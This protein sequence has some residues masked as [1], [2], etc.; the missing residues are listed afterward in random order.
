MVDYLKIGFITAPFGN[1]GEVKVQV[2]TD[3]PER[4]ND[5]AW[6]FVDTGDSI[7]KYY[8]ENTRFIRNKLI[9]KFKGIDTISDA[10]KL[11]NS[12][13]KVRREEAYQLP[14]DHYYIS[15]LIGCKV[16]TMERDFLGT[17][18]DVLNTGANDVLKIVDRGKEILVPVVKE[19]VKDIDLQ[20][21]K[22]IIEPI[23]GMIE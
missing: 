2:L 4:F 20:S 17:V 14:P 10:E 5:M 1:K 23:E 11:R 6:T 12:Y 19:F 16:F 22:I 8:I 15:D 7:Q 9:V 13:L 21:R 3:F 18:D